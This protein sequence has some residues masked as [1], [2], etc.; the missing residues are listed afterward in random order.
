[1]RRPRFSRASSLMLSGGLCLLFGD[2]LALETVAIGQGGT[3]DWQ[4]KGAAGVATLDAEYRAPADPDNP[5]GTP[6]LLVG[7]APGDLIEFSS[8]DFARALLP[9]RLVECPQGSCA[10]ANIA[11]GALA[12]GGTIQLPTYSS[13]SLQYKKP[14]LK[15]DLAELI[16][17]APGGEEGAVELKN[18]D[19]FGQLLLLDLGARFGVNRLR[20]YPRN[21]VHKSPAT[22]FQEDFL[23][24][25]ELFTNDGLD[26]TRE[27]GQVWSQVVL[28]RNNKN[29]VVDVV[30]DPPRYVQ[31][32]RLKS[33]TQF[34]WEIDEFEV[35]G[36]GFLPT[37]LYLSNILDAGGPATWVRLR[38][39]EE[40]R[41][42]PGLSQV[43]IRTRTGSDDSPFVFTRSLRG[44]P[45]AEEIPFSVDDPTEEMT[46]A[47]FESLPK[48]DAQG[49][50]WEPASVQD[51]LVN[52]SPFS[53]PFP[54]SAANGPGSPI[55]SPGPRR[56]LQ[57]QVLFQSADPE[58]VRVLRSLSV[59][60]LTPPLADDLVGEIFPRQVEPSRSSSFVYA[61]RPVMKTSG[62]RGFDTV[63]L[64]T[65]TKVES[66]DRLEVVDARGQPIASRDFAGLQ[67]TAPAD[68][69]QIVSVAKDRFTVRFP[70]I[71]EDGAQARIWFHT[72]I[73]TYSTNFSSSA[74][75]STEPLAAQAVT[76]GDA[77]I[78]GEGDAADFSGTTVLSPQVQRGDL[79]ARVELAPNPFT[80]NGDGVND[81]AVLRYSLLSLSLARPVDIAV[82][83]LAGR[84][85][86]VLYEGAEANGRYEDKTWDGRDGQG[87]LVAPGIYLV[88]IEARG[89]ATTDIQTH[90][91]SLAY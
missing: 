50:E 27:G 65:P 64:S 11:D 76:S 71:Q 63:D 16:T 12:R 77:A 60:F 51:D 56:Y 20:F 8:P 54:A 24:S 79:L 62:L 78:L 49:R 4:G 28:E 30:L 19:A 43:Q 13:F 2:A 85:V 66:I 87:R 61:V 34:N 89:D 22:P 69:F 53:T 57:F 1:M 38:W 36:E 25:Y 86:R 75:L 21:T 7:N 15:E 5:G 70:L 44:K 32:I 40:I 35:Y 81:Q 14:D 18:F 83:D 91:L 82:Y 3:L 41:G 42:D 46:R 52:W 39:E 31:S 88:R 26:L 9:K 37:A 84:L 48:I 29:P 45:N 47:E 33:L 59:D 6:K 74:S 68:G 67:D 90:T 17:S 10:E 73:L 72:S 58:A 80:P 55:L 23:R